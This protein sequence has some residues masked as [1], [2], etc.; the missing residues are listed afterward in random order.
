MKIADIKTLAGID[1]ATYEV[2]CD[3]DGMFWFVPRD[4]ALGENDACITGID[5]AGTTVVVDIGG[6]SDAVRLEY[7]SKKIIDDVVEAINNT[8]S[9]VND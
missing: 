9:F 3:G 6:S 2:H 8:L 1:P 4:V 5:K 7:F